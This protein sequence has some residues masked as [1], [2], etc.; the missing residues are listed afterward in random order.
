MAMAGYGVPTQ[1]LWHIN[2]KN[3]LATAAA[4]VSLLWTTDSAAQPS[5]A[6]D[7]SSNSARVV[8]DTLTQAE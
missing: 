7:S 2:L 1:N 3:A 5:S 4:A 6:Q 8:I